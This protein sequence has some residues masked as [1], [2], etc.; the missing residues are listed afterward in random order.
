MIEELQS[1]FV[2]LCCVKRMANLHSKLLSDQHLANHPLTVSE[3]PISCYSHLTRLVGIRAKI[4]AQ[5]LDRIYLHSTFFRLLT[6]NIKLNHSLLFPSARGQPDVLW[7]FLLSSIRF[8]SFQPVS[9]PLQT[10]GQHNF[11]ISLG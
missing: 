2:V 6:I 1:F 5:V 7:E 11:L 9:P 4:C 8:F 3:Q 10:K